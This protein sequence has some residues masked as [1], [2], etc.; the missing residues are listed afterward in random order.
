MK[1]V[2]ICLLS[3]ALSAVAA[4]VC[5][6]EASEGREGPGRGVGFGGPRHPLL[7]LFDEDRDGVLSAAEIEKVVAV[8]KKLDKNGDGKITMD[9]LPRFPMGGGPGGGGFPGPGGGQFLERILAMDRNGD[10]KIT[11]EEL[12]ERMQGMFSQ[13]DENGDGALDKEE[14]KK[15]AARMGRGPGG[16]GEAGRGGFLQRILSLDKN[17]DGKISKDEVQDD[18][19]ARAM[20]D[21]ID[22][23]A[24]GVL[25]KEELQKAAERFA[26]GARGR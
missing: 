24:D 9:E 8:L 5:L 14:L 23:D 15:V 4:N 22:A 12:P 2:T 11:K 1:R 10:G 21:R 18:E 6:A 20:F 3:V 25:T 16:P 7:M 26:P 19:R 17:G 13:M